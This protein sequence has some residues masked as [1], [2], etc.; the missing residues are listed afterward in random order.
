[1]EW[2]KGSALTMRIQKIGVGAQLQLMGRAWAC[3][4]SFRRR[5]RFKPNDCRVRCRTD[6]PAQRSYNARDQ[7]SAINDLVALPGAVHVR[8]RSRGVAWHQV[9]S[10]A[11]PQPGTECAGMVWAAVGLLALS[12]RCPP[13][14]VAFLRHQPRNCLITWACIFLPSGSSWV[15]NLHQA[16]SQL[17]IRVR[18]GGDSALMTCITTA[19]T[20]SALWYVPES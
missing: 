5:L 14:A 1:M 16:W 20:S 11:T 8:A 2:R 7:I 4:P 19:T 12:H 6:G 3:V 17:E 13:A 18:I 15:F 9:G 10:A